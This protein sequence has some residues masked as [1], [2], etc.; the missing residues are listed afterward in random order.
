MSVAVTQAPRVRT[1]RWSPKKRHDLFFGLLFVSPWILGFI[2]WTIA[3]LVSSL[4]YSFTRYDLLQPPAFIGFRNYTNLAS[5][6]RL[7]SGCPQYDV[8]GVF[9]APLGVL[10]AFLM[11]V[12]LNTKMVGRSFF[13]AIF[14]FPV[15]RTSDRHSDRVAVLAE[16]PIW[17]DQLDTPGIWILDHSVS[18]ES[19]LCKADPAVDP[20]LGARRGDGDL[21]C[22]VARCSP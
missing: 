8:V 14:F 5:G 18:C 11:A 12:L 17:R 7:P 3:P 22:D 1:A 4:Y 9:S 2:L 21:P 10:S 15:D 19:G 20:L 13:R 16:H 6:Q